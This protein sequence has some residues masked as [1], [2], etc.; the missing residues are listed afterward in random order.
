ARQSNIRVIDPARVPERVYRPNRKLNLA[1]AMVTGLLLGL[2]LALLAEH[3][4]NTVKSAEE[5]RRLT[6]LPVIGVIPEHRD[7]GPRPIAREETEEAPSP[8][9][10]L[11][12]HTDPKAPLAEA[13]KELRT[14]TLLASPD[15]PPRT[16]LVTSC[17]P[18][19]GKSQTCLN[20]AIALAQSG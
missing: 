3:L 13:Y 6:H 11:I 16:L 8:R 9:I 14:A 20:L 17:L 2:G 7:I 5:V 10:D 12:T 19:E 15:A 4:D 1:L 18:Q